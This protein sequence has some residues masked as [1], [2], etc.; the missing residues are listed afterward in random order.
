MSLDVNQPAPYADASPGNSEHLMSLIRFRLGVHHLGVATG[1]WNNT[2]KEQ[3]VCPRCLPH[4]IEDELHVMF[5]CPWYATVHEHFRQV[6]TGKDPQ[7]TNCMHS[8]MAYRNQAVLAALV[9][10]IDLRHQT[11][12][13]DVM[14]DAFEDDFW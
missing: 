6:F 7:C 1:R 13:C 2:P 11:A 12:L 10:A 14:I 8:I 3:Q 9:H 5:E 4:R